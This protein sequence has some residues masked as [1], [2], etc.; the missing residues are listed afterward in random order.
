MCVCVLPRRQP[1]AQ[2]SFHDVAVG[3]IPAVGGVR[4]PWLSFEPGALSLRMDRRNLAAHVS[5]NESLSTAVTR[6]VK[7]EYQAISRSR[8]SGADDRDRTTLRITVQ[9]SKA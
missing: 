1:Q 7:Q 2:K 9:Q 8:S 3:A 4:R 5:P 6:G